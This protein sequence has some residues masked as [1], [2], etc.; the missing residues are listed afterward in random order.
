MNTIAAGPPARAHWVDWLK[1]LVVVGIA[2]YHVAL[3]FSIT[4][5]LISNRE[6]S[7]ALS[8][9][10]GWGYLF[11][12]QLLFVLA[13]A[14]SYYGRRTR[15]A[16]KFARERLLR[17]GVPLL[18]GLATLSPLQA[19]FQALSAGSRVGFLEW[20]PGYLHRLAFYPDPV[21]LIRYGYHLWFL[22]FLLLISLAAL[23]LQAAMDRLPA[24][25][26]MRRLANL[27]LRPGTVLLAAVPIALLQIVLRPA[28]P[29]DMS[30]ADLASDLVFYLWGFALAASPG[31][32]EAVL[33]SQ[34]QSLAAAVLS[35]S[36]IGLMFVLSSLP[37]W[38][39]PYGLDFDLV[40][41]APLHALG[42]WAFIAFLVATAMRWWNRPHPLVT[43]GQD[44][45]LPFYVLHHPLV[46]VLGFYIVQLPIPVWPKFALLLLGVLAGTIGIYHLVIR[47]V[48]PLRILFGLRYKERASA[49]GWSRPPRVAPSAT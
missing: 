36:G 5:W 27:G 26:S 1:V 7:L 31:F 37:G 2:V 46:V 11:G 43:Y 38:S 34:W 40:V 42:C 41:Y 12:L 9:Y 13:G 25:G 47:P 10:V 48:G 21:W 30:W 24:A 20:L 18:L 23:P 28:A 45:V 8:A 22:G 16:L 3:V 49:R 32:A 29:A 44:A 35:W 17:L 19:Y 6:H 15:T 33:R 4:P 39:Q 14:A